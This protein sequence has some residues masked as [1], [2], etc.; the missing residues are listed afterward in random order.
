MLLLL[1]KDGDDAH[2]LSFEWG[3]IAHKKGCYHLETLAGVSISLPNSL[4][5]VIIYMSCTSLII[6]HHVL[7]IS[8]EQTIREK[9]IESFIEYISGYSIGVRISKT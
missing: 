8:S 2:V 6:G 4:Y 5:R 7:N 3:I 1:V 9:L